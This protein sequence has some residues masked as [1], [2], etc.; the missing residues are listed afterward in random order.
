MHAAAGFVGERRVGV[1]ARLVE[2][3]GLDGPP[4]AAERGKYNV[5][6]Y[7]KSL[8]L[9]SYRVDAGLFVSGKVPI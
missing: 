6:E 1:P 7:R 3:A 5:L 2:L 9:Q 4:Q 8:A